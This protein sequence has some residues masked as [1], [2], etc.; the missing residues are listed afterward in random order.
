MNDLIKKLDKKEL[1]RIQLEQS[2]LYEFFV[3]TEES[4]KVIED[5]LEKMKYLKKI[6]YQEFEDDDTYVLVNKDVIEENNYAYEG[7]F[8]RQL[9]ESIESAEYLLEKISKPFEKTVLVKRTTCDSCKQKKNF[10]YDTGKEKI[11]KDCL[12]RNYNE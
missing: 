2:K 11:C 5:Y 12:E 3:K 7:E 9:E 6:I 10:V 8:E 4:K 1:V